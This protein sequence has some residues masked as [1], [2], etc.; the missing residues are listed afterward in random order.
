MAAPVTAVQPIQIL[1]GNQERGDAAVGGED[2]DL[3]Q[4]AAAGQQKRPSEDVRGL[5]PD[6]I[7]TPFAK[8]SC[9]ELN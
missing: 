8:K 1:A 4:I 7:I 9:Q 6:Q 5:Q 2:P 3:G